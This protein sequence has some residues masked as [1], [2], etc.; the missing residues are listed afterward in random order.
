VY[1]DEVK[2]KAKRVLRQKSQEGVARAIKMGRRIAQLF[3]SC[4]LSPAVGINKKVVY[5]LSISSSLILF[6]VVYHSYG[7]T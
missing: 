2:E 4:G 6:I 7:F 5:I 3:A 1:Y